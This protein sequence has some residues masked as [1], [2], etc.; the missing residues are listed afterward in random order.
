MKTTKG[1]S[2]QTGQPFAIEEETEQ[3]SVEI[4][5]NAKGEA[6]VTAKV[7]RNNI[8]VAT[9]QAVEA[10]VAIHSKLREQG[11]RVAGDPKEA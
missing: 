3:D 4:T 2:P 11:V 8:R 9:E 6:Q 5:V 1:T 10:L 7:Y